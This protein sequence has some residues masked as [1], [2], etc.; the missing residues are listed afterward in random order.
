MDDSS[1]RVLFASCDSLTPKSKKKNKNH[2]SG[3]EMFEI[4]PTTFLHSTNTI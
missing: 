2:E 4:G 1:S 3:D